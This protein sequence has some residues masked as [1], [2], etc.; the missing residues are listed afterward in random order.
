MLEV[1]I[2]IISGTHIRLRSFRRGAVGLPHISER[3]WPS[4]EVGMV[5]SRVTQLLRSR[6]G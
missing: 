4:G 1:R 2:A 5:M 3:S 6:P